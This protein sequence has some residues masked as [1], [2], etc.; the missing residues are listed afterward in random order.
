[1]GT[2]Y[3]LPGN[4]SSTAGIKDLGTN[5]TNGDVNFTIIVEIRGENNVVDPKEYTIEVNP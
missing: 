5:D 1:V 4:N 2:G 3:T